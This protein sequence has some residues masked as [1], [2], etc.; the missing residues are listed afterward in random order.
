MIAQH[1]SEIEVSLFAP[2]CGTVLLPL[3]LTKYDNG[4]SYTNQCMQLLYLALP[5]NDWQTNSRCHISM[6]CV[7]EGSPEG[8]D[9]SFISVLVPWF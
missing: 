6:C 5:H 8:G 2:R 7:S 1:I 9:I 3:V 4:F